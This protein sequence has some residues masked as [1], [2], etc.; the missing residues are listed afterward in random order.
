MPVQEG[1]DGGPKIVRV[2]HDAGQDQ[3]VT[4]PT[5]HVDRFAYALVWM[6]ASEEQQVLAAVGAKI[7][8]V[9]RNAV[10]NGGRVLELG[11]PI[12]RADCHQMCC[13]VVG[14]VDGHNTLGREAMN[15]G[16]HW[17]AY[18]PA[19]AERQKVKMIVNQI[20]LLSLLEDLRNMQAFPDL[21]IQGAILRVG[22]RSNRTERGI[23][24]RVGRCE[25]GHVVPARSQSLG[26][27]PYHRLPG[28][29][30]A[31]RGAP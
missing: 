23:G 13:G 24:E 14:A 29:V 17:R 16:Q 30:M 7:E 10:M 15:R 21:R 31:R 12:R 1:L 18:Q 20:E 2:L 3:L 22:A 6:Q 4:R 19:V 25:Q 8:L 9:Q 26:Q 5:S 28:A 11:S 27:V